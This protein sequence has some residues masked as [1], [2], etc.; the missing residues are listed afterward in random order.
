MFEWL[1][2]SE[3][4]CGNKFGW[5][6]VMMNPSFFFKAAGTLPSALWVCV[7][8]VCVCTAVDTQMRSAVGEGDRELPAQ[9][10]PLYSHP[11][12]S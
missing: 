3:I 9:Q 5:T 2:R 7:F 1:L 10:S 6:T 4:D 11:I 8:S 12:I